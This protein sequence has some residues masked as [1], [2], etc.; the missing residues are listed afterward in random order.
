[1]QA[2][3]GN[4]NTITTTMSVKKV[5]RACDRAS[6]HEQRYEGRCNP[7]EDDIRK[8]LGGSR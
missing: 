4:I 2:K 7:R 1:M 3:P 6:A 5:G 8:D